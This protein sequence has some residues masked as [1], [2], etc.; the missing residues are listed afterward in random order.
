MRDS[1]LDVCECGDYRLQHGGGWRD[2]QVCQPNDGMN[3]R[4][5]LMFRPFQLAVIKWKAA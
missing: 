1:D 5:C 2:C 3:G 4:E